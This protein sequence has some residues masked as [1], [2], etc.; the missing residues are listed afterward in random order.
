ML[1]GPGLGVV[2]PSYLEAENIA[3]L[4]GEVLRQVP[5]ARLVVVDDSPDR[6]T[7]DVVRG[8][9]LSQVAAIHRSEKGGR[10]SAV[11]E[12]IAHLL[13]LGCTQV[14]EMDADFSH[15]PAQIPELLTTARIRDLDLLIASRYLP[16][17][18]ILNWPVSRRAFSRCSNWLAR[19]LLQVP[20]RD[21]TNGYRLYSRPAADMITAHCGQMGKGFISLSEIL[22]NAYYRGFRVGEI[23][24]VFSNRLRGES[25]ANA[26]EITNALVGLFRI[27]GLKRRLQGE[28]AWRT[29]RQRLR[30]SG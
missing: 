16:G 21:Y 11:L 23:P 22:V 7:V 10:G 20:V 15:P 17:S 1:A 9:E 3:P 12:G 26:A 25:S 4:I 27:Y 14:L 13:P 30:A 24:T 28:E 2:I 5:S 29:G 8:L 18:R 19:T 6:R